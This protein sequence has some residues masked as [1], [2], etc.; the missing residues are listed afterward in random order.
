MDVGGHRELTYQRPL[1]PGGDRDLAATGQVE[2][3]QGVRRRL[4]ERLVP[5]HGRDAEQL[6]L[7]ARER[8]QQRDR[9]VV[10][11]ITVED[12]RGAHARSIGHRPLYPR[13]RDEGGHARV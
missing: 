12:D 2:H 1:G 11:W 13:W 10:P 5:V 8:Q 3:A 9:I 4:G 6:Q 7:G